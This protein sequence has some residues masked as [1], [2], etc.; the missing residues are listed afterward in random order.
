MVCAYF[1][2]EGGGTENYAY[3]I[4]KRLVEKGHSITVLC[5]THEKED[6]KEIIDEISVIRLKPNF[7]VSNT[8]IKFNSFFKISKLIKENNFDLINAHIPLLYYP[9]IGIMAS[10]IYKIP[11]VLTWH[12]GRLTT[13]RIIIDAIAKIYQFSI[14]KITLSQVDRIITVSEFVKNNYLTKYKNK[15]FIV[16]PGVDITKFKPADE[17]DKIPNNILFVAQLIKGH[18]WKGLD[19]LLE[20]IKLIKRE[21]DDITLTVVGFGDYIDHYKD[22]VNELRIKDNII[23]KGK[24]SVEELVEEYQRANIFVL[25]PTASL[26][27]FPLVILEAYAC[28]VPIIGANIGAIPYAIKNNETCLLVPPKDPNALADAI[29]YLLENKDVR[30]KMG[31]DGRKLVKEK[32]TWKRVAEMTEKVYSNLIWK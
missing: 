2:P 30:E 7:I 20:S 12:A 31:K 16:P 14:G 13:N 1:Y 22:Q 3:N 8:P 19:Y 17:L 29:I 11:S 26:D 27:A 4:A 18:R 25:Y 5:S 23:F 9:D 32:Y 6:K 21:I 24:I 28:E 15:V 10:K